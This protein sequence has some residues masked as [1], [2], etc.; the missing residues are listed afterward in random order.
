MGQFVGS[1]TTKTIN[2]LESNCTA[3][4]DTDDCVLRIRYQEQRF[5]E[6]VRAVGICDGYAGLDIAWFT[7]MNSIPY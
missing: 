3:K 2:I 5:R 4:V 7:I 1:T 6:G